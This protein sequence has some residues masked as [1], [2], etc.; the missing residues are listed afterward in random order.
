M[1]T[2]EALRKQLVADRQAQ[3]RAEANRPRPAKVATTE[4]R[5]PTRWLRILRRSTTCVLVTDA[6]CRVRLSPPA[7]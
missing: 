5:I 4:R 6:D 1:H 3:Y 2:S 7:R